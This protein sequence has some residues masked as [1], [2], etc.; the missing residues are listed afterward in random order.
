VADLDGIDWANYDLFNDFLESYQ[1]PVRWACSWAGVFQPSD[2]FSDEEDGAGGSSTSGGGVSDYAES[3]ED[4]GLFEAPTEQT[5]DGWLYVTNMINLFPPYAN[6]PVQ[7]KADIA[8]HAY[9]FDQGWFG[10]QVFQDIFTSIRTV[11]LM[12]GVQGKRTSDVLEAPEYD[13]RATCPIPP[14]EPD[15]INIYIPCVE[16]TFEVRGTF[17]EELD[18][19]GDT[20]F[21]LV[22]TY[23]RDCL[24]GDPFPDVCYPNGGW[25]NGFNFQPLILDLPSN[26][27]FL[28]RTM[29]MVLEA[30]PTELV[31]SGA[32]IGDKLTN[33]PRA[34]GDLD[35]KVYREDWPGVLFSS[36][37]LNNFRFADAFTNNAAGVLAYE[38]FTEACYFSTGLFVCQYNMQNPIAS[39]SGPVVAA[40][41]VEFKFVFSL[42]GG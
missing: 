39:G 10:S 5:R 23:V 40:L 33:V 28:G 32:K 41:G 14:L 38:T 31:F 20:R 19:N 29:L 1:Q 17:V 25:S 11:K 8:T 37:G 22:P 21:R 36:A 35:L 3:L 26:F 42:P 18:G 12:T 27:P 9:L 6:A 24:F 30:Q 34:F 16:R 4:S 2:L 15:P 13:F 7:T